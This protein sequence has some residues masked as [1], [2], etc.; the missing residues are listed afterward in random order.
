MRHTYPLSEETAAVITSEAI[1]PL[2]KEM[3]VK[4][5]YLYAILGEQSADPYAKFRHMF[6]AVAH[7]LPG[8]EHVYLNDLKNISKQARD[9]R[10]TH[11]FGYLVNNMID[12]AIEVQKLWN[13]NAGKE[14]PVNAM[15]LALERL[16]SASEEIKWA[17][18]EVEDSR[19]PAGVAGRG[20]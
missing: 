12:A 16:A 19:D 2:A 3:D 13:A 18:N 17:V 9:E 5:T 1:K 8:R 4:R 7:A 14:M 20:A 10:P 15:N 6:K 11:P